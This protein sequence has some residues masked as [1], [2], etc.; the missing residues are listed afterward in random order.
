VAVRHKRT[1]TANYTWTSEDLV[2]GQIGL[3]LTDGTAHFKRADG[4]VIA[5]G[6]GASG[7]QG[8]QGIQGRQG[9]QGVQGAGADGSQGIQG[10][11]GQGGSNGSQGIQGTQGI[12]GSQGIQGTQGTTGQQGIQGSN[13]SQ[14]TQG[15]TGNQ[16]IQGAQGIGTAG[17]DGAQGIQGVQGL[18]GNDANVQGIQGITGNQGIQGITGSGAQGIQGITGN[19]GIQGIT[20]SGAQG[21]QGTTGSYP[22]TLTADLDVNGFNI[23]SSSNGVIDIFPNGTGRVNITNLSYNEGVCYDNGTITSGTL[24]PTLTN[25]SNTQKVTI[26]GGSFTLNSWNSPVV[27]DS[28]TL[29]IT[30]SATIAAITQGT[31]N[32]KWAGGTRALTGTAGSVDI[33]SVY[34]DGST[35][36]ASIN[37]GFA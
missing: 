24:T 16:G 22:P 3:N 34:Y 21:I 37:K 8:I 32:W 13:G 6:G 10:I 14:G 23:V 11:Q 2:E 15:I 5:I 20:G 18:Q 19:Q 25:R 28:L 27:G 30:N 1:T 12:T 35:Y 9:I 4:S 33:L 31:G 26:A 17:G 7:S 29:I 36:F